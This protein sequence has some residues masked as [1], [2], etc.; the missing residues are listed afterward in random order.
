MDSPRIAPVDLE[1]V[2]QL[3]TS[4]SEPPRSREAALSPGDT[5]QGAIHLGIFVCGNVVGVASVGPE[6]LPLLDHPSGWRI[7]G[8]VVLPENRRQGLGGALVEQ[9]LEYVEGQDSPFAWCYAKPRLLSYY[10]RY[11]M[12]PTGHTHLHPIGGPTL[13]FGSDRTLNLIRNQAGSRGAELATAAQP[14]APG[15]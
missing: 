10:G 12:R 15:L 1:T 8:M 13:L 11:G 9:L 7:R 14:H 3:R 5:A 6:P 2:L 4:F